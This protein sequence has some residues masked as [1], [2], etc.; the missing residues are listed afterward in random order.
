MKI[1]NKINVINKGFTL[2]EILVVIG[3]IAVLAAVVLVAINPSRQFKLARDSQRVSNVNAILNTISQNIAEH[4]GV[5]T[6]GL[7]A[8][9]IPSTTSQIKSGGGVGTF[10]LAP[11]VVPVYISSLPYDPIV[12][13][14]HF[15]SISDYDTGYFISVDNQGR[16]TASSTGEINPSITVTR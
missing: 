2:I 3:I 12:S 1:Q 7:V 15:N 11:C 6:C 13:G 5:F 4:H 8:T 14:A 9:S 16:V 10:D